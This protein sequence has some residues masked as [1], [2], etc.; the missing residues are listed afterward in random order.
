MAILTDSLLAYSVSIISSQGILWASCFGIL[1]EYAGG[2]HLFGL[3]QKVQ[4]TECMSFARRLDN[5]INVTFGWY[6]LLE[7][8]LGMGFHSKYHPNLFL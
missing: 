3:D 2:V 5:L 1:P 6:V 4:W 7:N 8:L